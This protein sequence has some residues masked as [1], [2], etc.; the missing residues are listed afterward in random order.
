[1]LCSIDCATGNII[2]EA[3]SDAQKR[4]VPAGNNVLLMLATRLDSI[5]ASL[6]VKRLTREAKAPQRR[7]AIT[8]NPNWLKDKAELHQELG[9]DY[10]KPYVRP[11]R[12]LAATG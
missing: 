6:L 2:L 7:A 10:G 1:M 11:S 5:D 4:L 9:L 8:S 3:P 12:P